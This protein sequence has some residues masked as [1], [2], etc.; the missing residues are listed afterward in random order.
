MNIP[1]KKTLPRLSVAGTLC[2]AV[3]LLASGCATVKSPLRES[4][5][6]PVP[7]VQACASWYKALDHAVDDAKVRDAE[8]FR[9]PGFPYLRTDRFLASFRTTA[10]DNSATFDAWVT[11]LEA[12]DTTARRYEIANLPPAAF[13]IRDVPD[14]RAALVRTQT[15]AARLARTDLDS[16]DRRALLVARAV[17]PDAYSSW[18][19]VV[20]LYALTRYPFMK[21]V[22]GW[23]EQAREMFRD[24]RAGT[25]TSAPLIRH[26]AVG[27]SVTP[28]R[29]A[30]IFSGLQV[31]A[32]GIPKLDAAERETLLDAYAPVYDIETGGPYDRFGTLVWQGHE[33]P[34]VDVD[35][36]VVYRRLAFTQFHGRSLIQLV[37]TVWFSER[38]KSH[39]IDLLAGR[40]D[41]VVFRV[42][43][44][45]DGLP[46]V[47]DTI[48]PCG[49]YHMFFP[50]DRVTPLPPPESG[51]E[52][53]F[54]PVT[55][56]AIGAAQ[57]VVVRIA[58][59]THYVVDVHT[60]DGPD[61]GAPYRF[62]AANELRAMPL[63]DDRTRSAF[64][65]D[66]IVPGTNR[67]EHL[68]FWPM[69]IDD[70]GAMRQWGNHATAF[71][72]RRHFEDADLIEKRFALR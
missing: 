49:C 31:D 17:V 5:N 70:S 47:Y 7:E 1:A 2:V 63:G 60:L 16:P 22:E 59:R 43:L 35:R 30:S 39:A 26:H 28:D 54:I 12:L 67:M 37:Y 15:C 61:A 18:K 50:T 72:G 57:P 33:A 32:L 9:I 10:A 65:P 8:D 20:G 6:S 55:L 29:I 52:W 24:A 34:D 36:P 19:R 71:I 4:L 48:H 40:L 51:M 62:A 41:G 11:H 58:S 25:R 44:G 46:L 69:G 13:P 3:I 38:P 56:P 64:G 14:P 27:P 45:P 23:H 68:L 66:G 21:G 42:T 53:A